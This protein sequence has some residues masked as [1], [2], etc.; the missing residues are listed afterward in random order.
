MTLD[1][2]DLY[3]GVVFGD[4][5]GVVCV[6]YG[7]DPYW[8]DD[9][10]RHREWT[11]LRYAWPAERDRLAG[12]AAREMAAGVV[13]IYICPAVRPAEAR[14]RRKGDAL[15]PMVCWADLDGPPADDDLLAELAPFVVSSGRPGHRHVYVP[16]SR[17]MDLAT[18]R[19]LQV[20]LRDRLGGDDKIADNDLLRLPGTVN[21]KDTPAWPVLVEPW[22]GTPWEPDELASLLEL[23]PATRDTSSSSSGAPD[24]LPPAV[25]AALDA[26]TLAD[27]TPVTA[28]RSRAHDRLVHA[29]RDAGLSLAETVGICAGYEPSVAKYGNRLADEV[30]RSWAKHESGPAGDDSEAPASSGKQSA[31]TRLVK[32]ALAGYELHVSTEGEPFGVP[33]LGPRLVRPLRGGKLGLRAELARRYR[34]QTGVVA[35]QQALA[36]GLL[37]LEGEAAQSDPVPLALRV[38]QA[39]DVSWLDLGDMSGRAVKITAGGWEVAPEAP[40]LFKRTVLSGVLPEPVPGG[41]LAELWELLNVAEEDRPLVAAWLVSTLYPGMPHPIPA[42]L[43]EQGTGKTTAAKLL[44]NLIDPSPVQVRKAPRDAD[45]WITAAS[46]SWVV[47]LDNLSTLTDWLSDTLCRAVT[48]DG[49]VRRQLYTDGGLVVFAFR[50]CVLLTGIDLGALRGDLADRLLPVDLHLIG[51]DDRRLDGEIEQA[52]L[53]AHPRILGAVLDLAAGVAGALPSVRLGRY[54]RMADFARILA[55]VD[56]VLCTEGYGRYTG[57]AATLAADSL[58]GDD[59]VSAMRAQLPEAEVWVGTSAELFGLV[60]HFDFRTPRGWPAN[61]RDV[62]TRLKRQAPVM[63]RAGWAIR[64]DA[65]AGHDKVVRWH[66]TPP[67]KVGNPPPQPPQP[68]QGTDETDTGAGVAGDAGV[69]YGQSQEVCSSCGAPLNDAGSVARGTCFE[70]FGRSLRE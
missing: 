57:R 43:G 34:E 65:A 22:A 32:L 36:D 4:R 39:G 55:A 16:L 46:G 8:D 54:P 14:A 35:P 21:H 66:I 38:G 7:R 13:D 18:W 5:A 20:A 59:F 68:P 52:W 42:L 49:D 67:E 48:G 17:P 27:G 33:L 24:D 25:R 31:A 41:D 23:E 15:P 2:F 62:T 10:Y 63:R 53:E 30:A 60:K 12:D 1:G 37:A 45:A 40:M 19:T 6:G 64:E 44:A 51:D 26:P 56:G 58:T 70:C 3:A 28:D 11:E 69:R 9:R 50:R 61:A 29:C 47:A